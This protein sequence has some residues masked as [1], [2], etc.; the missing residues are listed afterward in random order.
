MCVICFGIAIADVCGK[1]VP[2]SLIMAMCRSVLRS[3]APNSSSAAQVLHQVNRQL[4]PDIR[5]DMFISMAYLIAEKSS[6]NLLLARAGHDP[7]L[8]YRT[9]SRSVEKVNPSGMA[10]GIDS[11]GV[12]DRVTGDFK[13]HVERGDCLILYTD[14][15]TEALD[16]NGIEFGIASLIEGI[17]GSAD[18][19][20]H[21]V[22]ALVTEKVRSF[23][24]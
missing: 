11:E 6:D 1:G 8:L 2:A 17:H 18:E 20:A 4:Y 10:L 7:P 16:S 12:F 13:G 21:T 5:E 14:G 3:V 23:V 15:V 24:G 19:S 22:V 9:A